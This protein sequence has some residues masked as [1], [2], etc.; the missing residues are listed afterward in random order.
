MKI[1]LVLLFCIIWSNSFSQER[2][3]NFNSRMYTSPAKYISFNPLGLLEPQTAICMGVG[4]RFSERSEFF[5]EIA[6]LGRNRVYKYHEL[7]FYHG[8][9]FLAQYR[10][11]FLQQWRPIINLGRITEYQRKRR[12]KNQFFIGVEFR[13]KPVQF[14]AYNNFE[15]KVTADTLNKFK[16][17]ASTQSIGGAIL[18]GETFNLSKNGNW[19]L[20]FTIGIGAKHKF[21]K[22]KNLPQGYSVVPKQPLEW[23][24]VPDIDESIG[25]PYIPSTFRLR[26]IIR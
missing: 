14:S 8:F 1:F 26:Y 24:F 21:V 7:V 13:F 18:L 19:F 15:N 10:Y 16:Y 17:K 2:Q 20:E 23:N 4:T 25:M 12:Q 6:Y 9:R 11:H 5:T 3:S 22:Y